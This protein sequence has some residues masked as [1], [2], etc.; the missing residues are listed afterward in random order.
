MAVLDSKNGYPIWKT[1]GRLDDVFLVNFIPDQDNDTV[2]DVLCSHSEYNGKCTYVLKT[3]W[4]HLIRLGNIGHLVLISGSTGNE[5]KRR[6]IGRTFF[7]PQI[8]KRNKEWFV[9]Y[10]TGGPDS[11]GSLH[12][13][14]LSAIVSE[15]LVNYEN[16]S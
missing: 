14:P 8:F 7:M 16:S 1:T 2:A 9:L 5:L 4:K 11:G 13:A 10:G 15:N 3:V 12:L 6:E